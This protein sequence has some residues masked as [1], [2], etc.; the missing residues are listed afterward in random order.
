M[1]IREAINK[2]R[3][4]VPNN[5]FND[6]E[7]IEWLDRLDRQI[8]LEIIDIRCGARDVVF[9]GYDADTDESKQLLVPN[10]YDEVYVLYLKAQ[11]HLYMNEFAR[12]NSA[13]ESFNDM[14][15]QFRNY[16]NR[17]HDS[18]NIRLKI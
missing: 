11:M 7:L 14:L 16:Y 3:K 9:D 8:K 13:T 17:T 6:E 2:A 4:V 12:Y 1:T 10:P 5:K 18:K 15:G